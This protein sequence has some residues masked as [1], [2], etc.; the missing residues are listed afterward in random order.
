MTFIKKMLVYLV[1]TV[2]GKVITFLLVPIYTHMLPPADYGEADLSY[3]LVVMLVSVAFMELWTGLLRFSYDREGETEKRKLFGEILLTALTLLPL[4]LLSCWLG[5]MWQGSRYTLLMLGVGV[6]LL[7]LHLWQYQA[8]AMGDSRR[9]VIS[10][11][12]SS[13][14]Q[15]GT[16]LL[17]L[18]VFKA[19]AEML[20][21]AP[22]VGCIL[23]I[24]YLEAHYRLLKGK[25]NLSKK[26]Y[27]ELLAF[28]LP[29][30]LNAV[31]YNAM[32]NLSRLIAGDCLPEET[33]GYLALASK[34]ILIVT[35][36]V[37]IFSLAWQES[38]Y[39]KS[40]QS[41][42]SAWYSEMARLFTDLMCVLTA[43][44]ILGTQWIFPYVIGMDYQPTLEIMPVYYLSTL[45]YAFST[46]YGY[47][48]SAEKKNTLL[49]LSTIAGAAVNL[50]SLWFFF[51]FGMGMMA[52][53]L[54]LLLGYAV[55]LL[56][57]VVLLKGCIRVR[58]SR[59]ALAWGGGI[60]ILSL[61]GLRLPPVC[62]P[63]LLFLMAGVTVFRYRKEIKNLMIQV[64][65]RS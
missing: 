21:I 11:A 63:V 61:V 41:D 20:L 2:L 48:Y 31:A 5:A 1:G 38:A 35:S 7:C 17:G 24:L 12:I 46:F 28:S 30:A 53:P 39:E 62:Q 19:G 55:N 10:G 45:L 43:F 25:L 33:S 18:Y 56:L 37:Y 42:R 36:L 47:I 14:T 15:L 40:G 49:T 44:F 16:V 34:F 50:L 27:K 6:L 8:R 60:L 9:F 22:A 51:L 29:L 23:A 52:V 65:N 64:K 13:A 32:T 57:R 26:N 59:R 4:Y 54:A 58:L 3:T